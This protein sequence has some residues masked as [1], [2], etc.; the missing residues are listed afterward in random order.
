MLAAVLTAGLMTNWIVAAGLLFVILVQVFAPLDVIAG[1]LLV[2]AEAS[3]I[4]YEGGKLTV[5]L[6]I[7]TGAILV[8]L[9]FY[10]LARGSRSL[11][12]VR[13]GLTVPLLAYSALSLANAVR[14]NLL[15]YV[16]KD[17][18]IEFFPVIG[19]VGALLVAN[20]FDAR[21]HLKPAIWWLWVIGLGHSLV[22]FY[23]Y[24]IVRSRTAGVAFMPVAGLVAM[25][26]VNLALRAKH[27]LA[28]V[29]WTMLSLPLF[30]HQFLSFARGLWLGCLAGLLISFVLYARWGAGSGARWKRVGWILAIMVGAGLLAAVGLAVFFGQTELLG[31]AGSRFASI[32][33]TEY[34][35]QTTSNVARL[36]EYATT[37]DLIS[38]APWFGYGLGFTFVHREPI[39]FKII[40]QWW[41]HQNYLLVW[42]K[43][44]LVG[45][46]VFIWMLWAATALGIRGMRK[47][48]SIEESAWLAA[49][50]AATFFMVV[51]SLSNY[52]FDLVNATFP[53]GMLWGGAMAMCHDGF[54]R[55][56]WR[57]PARE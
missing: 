32:T 35:P 16:P 46:V 12:L 18:G 45:L 20:A 17:V 24:S 2:T 8:V 57:V 39:G 28:V 53:L 56:S 25:L 3:F 42:L 29:G 6:A 40:S 38:R 55:M 7:L 31:L 4:R 11:T 30:L 19:L 50:T 22:G 34:S 21:R 10:V 13:T 1:Y 26:P 44:G 15:G 36:A 43:Q 48:R 33:G 47:A 5:E 23:V 41:V 54:V 37:L 27:P 49:S 52:H 14:G 51:L 9:G